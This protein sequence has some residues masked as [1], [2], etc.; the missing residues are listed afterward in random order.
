MLKSHD[1]LKQ[2]GCLCFICFFIFWEL[3]SLF[4]DKWK[5][6]FIILKYVSYLDIKYRYNRKYFKIFSSYVKGVVALIW[7]V[8]WWIIVKSGPE[9]DPHISL[10]ELKYIQDSLG[11]ANNKVIYIHISSSPWHYHKKTSLYGSSCAK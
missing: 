5:L 8:A 4:Y 6:T 7:F 11:N 10:Q 1:S 3:I 9:E 2:L